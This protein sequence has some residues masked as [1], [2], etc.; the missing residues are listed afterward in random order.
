MNQVLIAVRQ[1]LND[2][3]TINNIEDLFDVVI[4]DQPIN[5]VHIVGII[6]LLPIILIQIKNAVELTKSLKLAEIKYIV[7]AVL[8]R[9]ILKN[10]QCFLYEIS[11]EGLKTLFNVSWC[12]VE[13]I[14]DTIKIAKKS[15]RMCCVSKI[16]QNEP[17]S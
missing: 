11:E 17:I 5:C 16:K 6:G 12:L 13:F 9:Y 10:K 4:K 3:T 2:N 8:Y 14:P 15:I 1:V 7:W